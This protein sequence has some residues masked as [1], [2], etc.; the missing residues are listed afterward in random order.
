[1]RSD[2]SVRRRN[3]AV[4]AL[5]T[6]LWT[7]SF[8][9]AAADPVLTGV[10]SLFVPGAGQALNGDYTDAAAHF[11]TFAV[12]VYG[13]I[14]YRRA[15]GYLDPD[16]RY[17]EGNNREFITAATLRQDYA[18]RLATDT[19]LY[20][21]YAAYR[22]ARARD[23]HGY[24]RPAPTETLGD[25]AVA[26]FQ[27]RYLSRP[28]TYIP[29][30]LQAIAAF[31]HRHGYATYRDDG[32]SADDLHLFNVTA[33]EMTAVGEEALFR[34]FVNNEFCDRYGD[35][36]GLV[37]SSLVFGLS[38]NGQGNTASA[39][40]ATGAGLYLGWLHQRNDF[41]AAE[42]AA[43]HYWLNVIAGAA[44]IHHGGSARLVDV[45]FNF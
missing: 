38:H 7:I 41:Q 9:A 13:V 15:R 17:D 22:D 37:F 23:N 35:T 25:L 45:Q 14:H 44:A 6:L 2:I 39:L 27:W 34:G 43:L 5:A 24:R 33:N 8:S 20:S 12:S 4:A 32:V 21:G 42:G 26:P 30:A 11:G 40:E 28:T 1:M 10:A 19:A 16:Q 31:G 18:L 3:R 29:L 36:K